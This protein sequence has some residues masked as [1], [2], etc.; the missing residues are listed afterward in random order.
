MAT[1][2]EASGEEAR[3]RSRKRWNFTSFLS[4]TQLFA[5]CP[6]VLY[7]VRGFEIDLL[8]AAWL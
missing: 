3:E 5:E 7:T 6:T 2:G 1:G 4:S 8:L